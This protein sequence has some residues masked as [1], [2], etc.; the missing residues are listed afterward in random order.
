MKL[1]DT[2]S[3]ADKKKDVNR[4]QRLAS[5]LLA[6]IKETDSPRDLASL[7]KQY[8]DCLFD[9]L[10]LD[11][12]PAYYGPWIKHL[13]TISL[14]LQR[15]MKETESKRDVATVARGYRGC[16]EDIRQLKRYTPELAET[17]LERALRDYQG[18]EH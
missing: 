4:L 2:L 17:P 6:Q 1:V 9:I 18:D 11:N 8:R 3:D 15:V 16:L 14:K 5:F 12:N 13:T 10:E 7:A